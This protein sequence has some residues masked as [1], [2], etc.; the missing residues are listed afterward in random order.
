MKNLFY[1]KLIY[2]QIGGEVFPENSSE[3]IEEKVSIS[4]ELARKLDRA[5]LDLY[6]EIQSENKSGPWTID[7]YWV[8]IVGS[9]ITFSKGNKKIVFTISSVLYKGIPE[10]TDMYYLNSKTGREFVADY[11]R[12][13]PSKSKYP[14]LLLKM[15]TK[16]TA[17]FKKRNKEVEEFSD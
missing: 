8:H 1:S 12:R 4:R 14:R 7:G 6:N 13:N 17:I 11:N 5:V 2:Q 3:P 10:S 15:L 9:K 16:L